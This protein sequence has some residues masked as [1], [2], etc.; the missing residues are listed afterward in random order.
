MNLRIKGGRSFFYQWDSGQTVV[1]EHEGT[2]HEVQFAHKGDENALTAIAKSIE[3]G[4]EANVPNIL[5]RSAEDIFAYLVFRDEDGTET[6]KAVRIPVLA[7]PKPEIYV[8]TETEVLNYAYLDERL[9][10]LEGEGLANAVAD[11]L[12]K[13]PPQAGAT[14][15]EAEQIEQNKAD[16]EQLAQEKLDADKLPE[17][18]NDALAQAKASGDFKGE[19]GDPGEPGAPGEKGEKGDPGQ[20]GQPGE[21]GPAG[22]AGQPGEKGDKGD[23]GDTGDTGPQGPE[24]PKGADGTGVTILGSYASAE[25]LNAQHPTGAPGDSYLVSGH[26]YVWSATTNAWEDVG[27]IQG[28]QGPRG[29][30]GEKGET[31]ATGPQGEKGSAFTYADFTPEQLAALKGDKGDKG[32]KGETGSQGPQGIQGEPGAPGEKGDKGDKGDPGEP[33]QK[34]EQGI[35][36]IPGE[37]G[38]KGDKGEQG[39]QGEQGPKGDTGPDGPQGPKGDKGETGATGPKGETGT[40]GPKGDTGA[41]GQRGTGLLSVTTA[42]SSY[43]TALGGITPKYRMAISTIKSQA[44]VTEVLLGDTIRYS[45]YQYPIDYL[46]ASYAYCTT[47]VS[48]RGAA[49]TTPVKGTDYFDGQNGTDGYTP[50]KGVDYFD[51]QDGKDGKDGLDATPVSPLFANSVDECTDTS[52]FYVLPDGFIYAYQYV[53]AAGPSYT[54]LAGN[55]TYD[56]RLSSSGK[57]SSSA[58]TGAAYTDFVPIKKGQTLR[59]KNFDVYSDLVA[60][61]AYAYMCFYTGASESK[62]VSSTP[63]ETMKYYTNVFNGVQNS[64]NGDV[65]TWTAFKINT[66]EHSLADSITHVRISGKYFADKEIIVTVDEE[67]TEGSSGGYAWV[68]TG[69]AFVPADYEDRILALE[70]Y[71]DA[72][73]E[74]RIKAIED[75][76]KEPKPADYSGNILYGKKWVACGDSFTAGGYNAS[77]GFDESVYIYQDGRF[78]GRQK[79]YPNIIGLRNNMDIVNLATGGQTMAN[80]SNSF[81]SRYSTIDADADYITIMLGINDK[82]QGLAVGT[83]EDSTNTT[84]CGAFNIAME[85]ILENH[86]FAHIGIMVSHGTNEEIME[87]TRGIAERWGVPYLDYGSPQVPLMNRYTGRN[88]CAKAQEIREKNFCVISDGTTPTNGHPNTAAHEY[89]STFIEAWLRTL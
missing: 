36:G 67:I 89:E 50:I 51:G 61:S 80:S 56:R 2:I 4:V 21:Q 7:R 86:P 82:V 23:K 75:A 31:G 16:I 37:K 24:G 59:I 30:R 1:V 54:N 85:H 13:N 18:V 42:P 44:G 77:D 45:Y 9:K 11:Y 19:K 27:N 58:V 10:E 65:V 38:E 72:I 26:L 53:E 25:E 73:P 15:E 87:A 74:S 70:D 81:M 68:N 76:L 78:A 71:A 57:A 79:V 39:I 52:K 69:H 20:P 6:R 63:S 41:T 47:R 60:G 33:G 22:A 40:Q 29:E 49:G 83:L 17:A 62:V 32:D 64:V 14:K 35:Q 84:F 8:Y 3:N 12:E 43:T 46:D 5:L 88:V 34:G 28:P 66:G 48:I 55:V